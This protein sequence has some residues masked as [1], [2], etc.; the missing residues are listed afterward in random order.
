M[1]EGAAWGTE[2]YNTAA[3]SNP[4]VSNNENIP[5]NQNML[6]AWDNER[7]DDEGEF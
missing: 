5:H 1:E 2:A 4:P 3:F 7:W 6:S